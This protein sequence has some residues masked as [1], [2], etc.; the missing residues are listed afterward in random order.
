MYVFQY[1]D[2]FH[3]LICQLA[4]L[5]KFFNSPIYAFFKS[6]PTIEYIQGHKSHVF[7]CAAPMC[8]CKTRF[9]H[10]FLD[11]SDARSTSNLRHHA[12]ICWSDEAVDTADGSQDVK[13]TQATLEGLKANK[14]GSIMDA[15]QKISEG[16][17][18]YSTCQH[19]KIEV[20]YA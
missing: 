16:K 15:F 7:E 17:A 4:R 6:L 1:L 3:R 2:Y 8:G 13:A 19:T 18:V 20:W 9:V 10:R 11:K 12:K 14:N 5:Q